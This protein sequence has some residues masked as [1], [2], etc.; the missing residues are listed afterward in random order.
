MSDSEKNVKQRKGNPKPNITAPSDTET[1]NREM[2][3]MMIKI[4]R[5]IRGYS[6]DAQMKVE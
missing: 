6:F 5:K 3:A 1:Q 2:R 4:N